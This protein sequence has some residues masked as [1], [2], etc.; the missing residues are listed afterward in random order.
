MITII[1]TDLLKLILFALKGDDFMNFCCTNRYIYNISHNLTEKFWLEKFLK[2][3]AIPPIRKPRDLTW[4]QFY[5]HYN[6]NSLK[7]FRVNDSND[8]TYKQIWFNITTFQSLINQLTSLYG[9]INIVTLSY[10]DN[11]NPLVIMNL[12]TKPTFYYINVSTNRY[13]RHLISNINVDDS[14]S[15][16]HISHIKIE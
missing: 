5:F 13:Y 10:D 4:K 7:L 3:Y 15:R 6:D 1:P 8:N 16:Q 12:Y 9:H 14:I 11:P 2:H